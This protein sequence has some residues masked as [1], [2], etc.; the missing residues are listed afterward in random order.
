MLTASAQLCMQPTAAEPPRLMPT[1]DGNPKTR[2]SCA[3]NSTGEN[4]E[5]FKERFV[6]FVDILGFRDIVRRMQSEHALF[7][8][9]RDALKT[10]EE[11]SKR[12]EEYRLLCNRPRTGHRASFLSPTDLEMTA[13]SDC[14][15][16][17]DTSAWQLLAA[18]Q[19]LGSNL[20]AQGILTR[21]A[22]VS[23]LAYHKGRVAFG[24]A[25]IEAYELECHVAKYPRILVTDAVCKAS[26]CED[27][28][29]WSGR[30]LRR[31]V[32]GCS[33]INVLTPPLSKWQPVS[34][35]TSDDDLQEFLGRVGSWLK[36]ELQ[37]SQVDLRQR[38]KLRWLAHHFNIVALEHGV[39][40]VEDP[41]YIEEPTEH[42]V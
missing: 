6:A 22:I 14:Y 28:T 42:S 39:D 41:P 34:T 16:I 36:S 13:F 31:D 12:I 5:S 29:F 3:M 25:V 4:L 37:R 38:S 32:D 26:H 1:L 9:A 21:G 27:K 20:L 10:I 35:D 15:L 2:S 40:I 7:V 17:S 30:L 24:P 8:T 23:G 11:Q 19:A 33:F 18:V